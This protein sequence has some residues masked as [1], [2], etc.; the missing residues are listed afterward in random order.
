M[1]LVLERRVGIPITLSV[2]YMEIARRL[3][4]PVFGISLP[5]HFVIQFDDG[6]YSTYIDPFNGGRPITAEE[7]FALAGAKVADPVL[8]RRATKKEIAIRMLQN[9]RGVYLRR[10]DWA[11]AVDTLDLLLVGVPGLSAWYKQ[12]GLLEL[13]L[14]RFQ[15]ARRDLEQYLALEPE[16]ADRPEILK[17]MQAIHTWLARVN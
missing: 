3:A 12:R 2:M 10:K 4:M 16:A 17:Q 6:N 13:E 9:L 5:R 8:L 7:C 14:K 15:A 1:Q 11:R